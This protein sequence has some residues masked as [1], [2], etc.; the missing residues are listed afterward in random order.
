MVIQHAKLVDICL[1][2]SSSVDRMPSQSPKTHFDAC[3][4]ISAILR[5]GFRPASVPRKYSL[6]NC[7]QSGVR[8]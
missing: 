2:T 3:E 6:T 7:F 1:A 8:H 4:S 5:S